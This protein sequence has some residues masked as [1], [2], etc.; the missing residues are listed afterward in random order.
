MSS[1]TI[2]RNDLKNILDKILPFSTEPVLTA[3]GS[4]SVTATAQTLTFCTITLQPNSKYLILTN[5]SSNKGTSATLLNNVSF[6]NEPVKSVG[7]VARVTTTSG[8]GVANWRYVEIGGSGSTVSL[9]GYSYTDGGTGYN[10]TG[11]MVAI[12]IKASKV[13][14][15]G[16][17]D[18]A[19]YVVEQGTSGI[20]TYRKWASG[21]AECWGSYTETKT[22]TGTT[23]G[24]YAY[25]A[26]VYFPTDLFTEVPIVTYSAYL[27]NQYA[28]TGTLTDSFS[29]NSISLWA[30]CNT[31]GSKTT[32]WQLN[33]KGKWK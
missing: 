27:G 13:D 22:H 17:Y 31:S 30:V 3:T 24:G 1:N 28:L 25:T 7:T 4:A 14:L 5:V 6:T 15:E 9:I 16:L 19:D 10:Q 29:K 18:C 20:W 12:P 8:Q 32:T 26:A 11:H 2:T 23:L 33:V 21:I